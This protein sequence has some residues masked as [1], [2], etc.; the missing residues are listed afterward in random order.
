MSQNAVDFLPEDYVEKRAAHRSAILF[1]GL[2][3]LVTG[4][5]VAASMLQRPQ[6]KEALAKNDAVN[7]ERARQ[8]K[9][10]AQLDEMEAQTQRMM[11]KAEVTAFLLEKVPRSALLAELTRMMVPTRTSLQTFELKTK[12]LPQTPLEN[13]A[14]QAM[15]DQDQANGSV[16]PVHPPKREV[17]VMVTGLA[18]SDGHV[19]AFMASCAKNPLFCEANLLFSEEYMFNET[20]MRRFKVEMRVNPSAEVHNGEVA[21]GGK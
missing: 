8:A 1:I 6:Y 19:A 20:M 5:L 3:T 18:P 21:T 16:E 11:R 4:G 15:K 13:K 14:Q 12:E 9:E 17:T 10:Q 2:F 7:Q